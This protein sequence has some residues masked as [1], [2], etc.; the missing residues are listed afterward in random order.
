MSASLGEYATGVGDVK[1]GYDIAT[2]AGAESGK[3]NAE[4]HSYKG[5]NGLLKTDIMSNS[6]SFGALNTTEVGGI[7]VHQRWLWNP[8]W[9]P[10]SADA[11]S[12]TADYSFTDM[13]QDTAANVYDFPAR[14]YAGAQGRRPSPD[15]AGLAAVD[16]TNPQSWNRYAYVMNNPLIYV[17]PTGLCG[18]LYDPGGEDCMGMFPGSGAPNGTNGDCTNEGCTF[19]ISVTVWAPAPGD[20]QNPGQ[21]YEIFL[22]GVDTG[23]NTC[24]T[25]GGGGGNNGGSRGSG[26]NSS[27]GFFSNLGKRL[28]CA[29]E[30]GDAHSLAAAT[31]TQ[32]SFLGKAFLGNTFSGLT[33]LGL[34][35]A[36]GPSSATVTDVG[37]AVLSGTHQGL[38]AKTPIGQ[39]PLGVAQDALVGPAAAAAFNTVVGAGT[40]T[41]EL[42][43]SG[44]R[45]AT[46]IAGVTAET[47]AGAV[48]LAKLGLDFA[49]FGY[50][51]VKCK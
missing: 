2:Y 43:I 27:G 38:P 17:D 37:I 9:A 48:A 26:G 44:S 39:G 16:P 25:I 40:Q 41:L 5:E 4:A 46:S 11:S 22:D 47:A 20:V 42:G 30:F 12:G 15:P 6:K 28:A 8:N 23:K 19:T 7:L 36:G 24:G 14:E 21:C 3:A 1:L 51:L 49:T 45:V 29:A 10:D 50:G 32:N 35:A 18:G 13:N 34:L 31:G 33:Q